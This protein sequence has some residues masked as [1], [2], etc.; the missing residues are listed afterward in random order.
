[1]RTRTKELFVHGS[2]PAYL[3]RFNFAETKNSDLSVCMKLLIRER[4]PC[5]GLFGVRERMRDEIRVNGSN[6]SAHSEKIK[7]RES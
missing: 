4:R 1:M 6:C 7:E 2:D 5:R 3:L